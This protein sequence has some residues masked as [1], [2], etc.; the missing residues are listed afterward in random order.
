ML[1]LTLRQYEYVTAI[2]RQGSLSAAA[3]DLNVSQPALSVALSRIETHLGHRLFIRRKGAPMALT[4]LGRSFAEK[5]AHLLSEAATLENPDS[6]DPARTTLSLGVYSDLAPFLLASAMELLGR[7]SPTLSVSYRVDGFED[8]TL[9][10]LNGQVDLALTYDLGLDAG[11]TSK[12]I[13]RVAPH[14]L[15]AADHP[16][17]ACDPLYLRDLARF[18]LILSREG[19]SAYH[20]LSLFHRVGLNPKVAHRADSLETL[21]SLVAR[22]FGV[23][24]AYSVPPGTVSYDGKP[25]HAVRICDDMAQEPIVLTRHGTDPAPATLASAIA[26]LSK[27]QIRRD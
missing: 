10:L 25:V 20:S 17:L 22:G 3:S 11:F 15:V 12:V 24:M 23:G 5:A 26:V 13:D 21:R 9:A 19:L 14:A 4:P 8:L 18:P 7:I 6:P 2:A 1:Y 16:L 27:V